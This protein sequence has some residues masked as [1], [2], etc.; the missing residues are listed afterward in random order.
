MQTILCYAEMFSESD[1]NSSRRTLVRRP[2]NTYSNSIYVQLH[3]NI[4]VYRTDGLNQP[5]YNP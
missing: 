4:D 5:I 3:H 1:A 2:G